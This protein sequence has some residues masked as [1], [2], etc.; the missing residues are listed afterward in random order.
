MNTYTLS[1]MPSA[2]DGTFG[3]LIIGDKTF[4]T[5]ELP[6]RDNQPKIS[7]VPVAMYVVKPHI[8]PKFGSCYILENVPN[9]SNVLIHVG[10]YA[11]DRSL[12]LKCDVEGCILIGKAIVMAQLDKPQRMVTN[13]RVA[14][15]EFIKLV[16]N[17][18]FEL[19]IIG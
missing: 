4:Y 17:K 16:G 19:E 12:D 14:F 3:T 1:R 7:C 6:W 2:D 9:R 10:N 15:T 8:S 5:A 11:G 13:S 18:A